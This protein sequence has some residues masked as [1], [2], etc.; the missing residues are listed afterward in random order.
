LRGELLRRSARPDP[1]Q[2]EAS[3]RTAL[4]IAPEQGVRG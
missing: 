2:A 3:F 1:A 4:A